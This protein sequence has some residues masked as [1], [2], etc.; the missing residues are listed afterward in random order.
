[1]VPDRLVTDRLILRRFVR[2]DADAITEAVHASMPELEKWLPWVH[3]GY[4]KDEASGF[5]RDSTQAWKEGRAF[6]F[7]IRRPADPLRHLGNVSIW[8]VSRM[9]RTGEIGYW[10]RSDETT[11]GIATEAAGRLVELGFDE[12]GFHKITL[13]I[14]VGNRQSERVA[15]KLG[16]V[17]EGVLREE[18]RIRGVWVDHGLFSLLEDEFRASRRRIRSLEN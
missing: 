1:M 5:I 6:D 17:K 3:P 14:A 9:G 8:H 12:L 16:F 13:R 18:L 10:V 7:A 2:R 15:E 4:S 11:N